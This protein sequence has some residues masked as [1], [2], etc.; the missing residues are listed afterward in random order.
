MVRLLV[1]YE[2]KYTATNHSKAFEKAF[3]FQSQTKILD[4]SNGCRS[5][6][7]NVF[8]NSLWCWSKGFLGS[9]RLLNRYNV[10]NDRDDNP[11]GKLDHPNR[12]LN[13]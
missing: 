10:G 1:S 6:I 9:F 7:Q 2:G 3:L 8:Q 4:V 12:S 13:L 5:E 11:R